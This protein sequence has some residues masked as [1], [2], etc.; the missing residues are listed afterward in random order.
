MRDQG[1]KVKFQL[2]HKARL[3]EFESL[4]LTGTSPGVLPVKSVNGHLFNVH[5]PALR[6]IMAGYERVVRES[7]CGLTDCG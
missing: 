6:K 2:I 1:L 5:H 3:S 7:C 4:F